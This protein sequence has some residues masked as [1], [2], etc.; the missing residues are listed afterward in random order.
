MILNSADKIFVTGMILIYFRMASDTIGH[1]TVMG[2]MKSAGFSE[3]V[4][5]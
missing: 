2:K 4:E 5:E 1:D 3:T